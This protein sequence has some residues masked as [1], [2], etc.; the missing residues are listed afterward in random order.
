[1]VALQEYLTLLNEVDETAHAFGAAVSV[2]SWVE[3]RLM[4]AAS[5]NPA[6]RLKDISAQR[7]IYPQHIGRL[8]R[9]LQRRGLV[10]VQP[11]LND[12]RART[13]ALT[14]KGSMV[15]GACNDVLQGIINGTP[16]TKRNRSKVLC[17]SI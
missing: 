7:K 5:E 3:Y 12:E 13:I 16:V 9:D 8:A 14:K 1:M 10:K 2:V 17:P 4:A 11:V 6:L 15:L